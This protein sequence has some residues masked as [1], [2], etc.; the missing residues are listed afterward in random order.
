[1]SAKPP[2]HGDPGDPHERPGAAAHPRPA[3]HTTLLAVGGLVVVAALVLAVR[4]A[5][6][7]GDTA[8]R[9]GAPPF[10]SFSGSFYAVSGRVPRRPGVLLRSRPFTTGLPPGGRAWLIL[11]TTT[12]ADGS[13]ALASA[14]VLEPSEPGS[15][16]LPVIAWAHPTTGI[17]HG[18]APSLLGGNEP[19]YAG[20]PAV[21]Q[22]VRHGWAIV[23]T[24]YP[25]LGTPG[26]TPYLIGPGEAHS[27]LDAVRA[28]RQLS[29]VTLSDR[30]VVWG[31]SQ[32]GQ[33]A[34]WTGA[35]APSYAPDVKLSGVAAMAPAT[36]PG[37]LLAAAEQNPTVEAIDAYTLTA[38]A[39]AYP[40]VRFGRYV[41]PESAATVR[42]LA[43]KCLEGP[44][45]AV[46]YV[47]SLPPGPWPFTAAFTSGPL[48]RRLAQNVPT[49]PIGVP[50]LVAQGLS[51]ELVLPQIQQRWV[52]ERC[53]AGQSMEYRTYPGRR[54]TTLDDEDS[55]LIP[56]LFAWTAQRFEGRPQASGCTTAVG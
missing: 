44:E 12:R 16:P 55:Q 34:L 14:L 51:D 21:Q 38:F 18:C 28:A 52:S 13:P 26:A 15:A 36:E 2:R 47:E 29:A 56:D 24:D 35:L 19:F 40:D 31:Y 11:Y 54:H 6:G 46:P 25:G 39:D 23:A 8:R 1:M 42:A 5:T 17:A 37:P 4:L 22:V 48:G 43:S 33:A 7:S 20:I 32:G 53:A 3:V 45:S 27:V 41:R 10:Q 50:L 49:R 9:A 30:T